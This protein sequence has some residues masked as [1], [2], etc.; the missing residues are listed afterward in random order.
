MLLVMASVYL[1][2]FP[3]GCC[4]KPLR[5]VGDNNYPPYLFVGPD[6]K[7]EGYVV[8]EWKLWEQRTG[9]KVEL[10]ATTWADAQDRMRRGQADVIEMIFRTP[11]R[12]V[13]YDF[14][15]YFATV[16]VGIYIDKRIAG[17]TRPSSLKGF[18]VGVQRGD[19][20][21]ERLRDA[22]VTSLR[23][24]R[25]YEDI[26]EA[27]Q[28]GEIRIF[29]ADR[30]PAAY[31]LYR[32]HAQN[33]FVK[34]FDFYTDRFRRGV[35]KGDTATLTLV[36][37]GMARIT[38]GERA[39]LQR[40][41]LGEPINFSGYAQWLKMVSGFLAAAGVALL[42][43]VQALRRA[44]RHRTR[45]LK[46]LAHHDALTNLPNRHLLLDRVEHA[47]TQRAALSVLLIDLDNFKRINESF[48]H[49][50]GD[51]LLQEVAYRLKALPGPV[52]TVAR[53]SGD[54]FVLMVCST[55][56]GQVTMVAEQARRE[57]ARAQELNGQ[58]VYVSASVGISQCPADGTDAV[59]LLKNADAAVSRAKQNGRNGIS[60]YSASLTAQANSFIT[61]GTSIRRAME[62][63]EFE[64]L[65]Q[66]QY[67]LTTDR[68]TGAEALVRWRQGSRLV[69]PAEFIAYAEEL[70]LI[71]ALGGWV[72]RTGCLQ[73]SSWLADGAPLI[74]MGINLSPHQLLCPGLVESIKGALRDAKLPAD[75]LEL[76]ITE[77]ALVMPEPAILDVLQNLRDH[78][79]GI[80]IDDF[81]TGY[82]SLAYLR[83]LPVGLIKIDKSFLTGI[84]E[85]KSAMD[86]VAAIVA[87]AHALNLQVI[88]EG[89]E[90]EA[91]ATFLKKVGCDFA[92]GW[93]YG[94]PMLP[95]QF[96]ELLR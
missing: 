85:Q 5:V 78:G 55:D 3:F 89:V 35:R 58:D 61:I 80:A 52:D 72:L 79:V 67:S 87:M 26:I 30:F 6:G 53:L 13:E 60:F 19:A 90:H 44:V 70:G 8:D 57:I 28:A 81:G 77:T 93:F 95:S 63:G 21:E 29:C 1:I 83:H 82:S 86:V 17:I 56:L 94:H 69:P 25:G 62:L 84:P 46:F 18:V 50:V 75:L 34:A 91:Q 16:Q 33:E 9:V 66:P 37:R 73:L 24:Y 76:E 22:G 14:T 7:P 31:Y 2:A 51:R 49:P 43:W 32:A 10:T 11:E 38:H 23:L 47:I 15:P 64:L 20:C 54:D 71:E 27:A 59:T 40:E 45:D 42:V 68:I 88:A 96:V 74:R 4:S 48:G 92:Q 65:Y 12:E 39:G 36:E 41:W